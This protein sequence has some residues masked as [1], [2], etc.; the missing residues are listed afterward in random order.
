MNVKVVDVLMLP[1]LAIVVPKSTKTWLAVSRGSIPLAAAKGATERRP[2]M[3][4]N[5]TSNLVL[6][7]SPFIVVRLHT[8]QVEG[9]T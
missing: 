9:V 6:I 2:T 7:E 1:V 3:Q 4:V 8:C 5:Q